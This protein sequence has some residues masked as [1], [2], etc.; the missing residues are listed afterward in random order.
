MVITETAE[1]IQPIEQS[2]EEPAIIRTNREAPRIYISGGDPDYSA[3]GLIALASTDESVVNIAGYNIE[4][5]VEVMMYAADERAMI[6]YLI[7][8][9]D[10]KQTKKGPDVNS[11]RHVT[12][13]KQQIDDNSHNGTEVFLPFDETGIW[14]LKVKNGSTEVHAFVLRSDNGVVVKEGDNQF[15]FWGQNF[16]TK[17]SVA[18]GML[19]LLNLENSRQQLQKISFDSD[20][21]ARARMSTQ[22]DIAL[23]YFGDDRVVIPLNLKYLNTDYEFNPFAPKGKSAEFFTF[24]DRPLYKPG[25]TVYFKTIIRDDD[26][27]RYSL[28]RGRGSVKIYSGYA[29]KEVLWEKTYPISSEGT[30]SGSYQLPADI[31]V[32][33]YTLS[34]TIPGRQKKD[35]DCSW[36]YTNEAHF[37]VE[38]FRKPEFSL[39]ATPSAQEF[40]RNDTITFT[41]SGNYFSGEPLM[42]QEIKYDIRSTDFHEYGF[43]N[44]YE[45]SF[46]DESG[47][48]SYGYWY[49][50]D[51]VKEEAAI[52]D[53][54][55]EAQIDVSLDPEFHKG[56]S[57]IVTIT[58]TVEDGSEEPSFTTKNVLVYAGDYGI[59]RTD[60]SRRTNVGTTQVIPLKLVSYRAG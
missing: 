32:G 20:G 15:I 50:G 36:Y 10:G 59:Y 6:D 7:H 56:R 39:D 43:I 24:T 35:N 25:D 27:G 14:Y 19:T 53:E 51:T 33:D 54:K 47:N 28:P 45:N 40:T 37:D 23:A 46:Q 34:I 55:G 26:D 38:F 44:N 13:I 30:I 2:F 3:G 16:K 22:A 4:D 48:Y 9:K 5:E 58:A 52:L 57:Q 12:T 49:G 8:D 18:K 21:I 31:K 42:G 60:R 17:R 1:S 11:L 29:E 41:L